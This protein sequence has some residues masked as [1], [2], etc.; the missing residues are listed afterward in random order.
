M[1]SKLLEYF[2]RAAELG[3]INKAAVDLRLSQPALSRNIALLEHEMGSALFVRGRGGVSLTEA[4]K[5]LYEQSRPLLR[6]F[7]LLKEQIGEIA[8]G[9]VAV[10]FPPSWRNVLTVQFAELLLASNPEI[11]IRI[12][13]TVS[14]SLR[15]Q[16]SSGLLD[17]CIA[18]ADDMANDDCCQMQIIREQFVAVGAPSSDLDINKGLSL[19]ALD[20]LPLIIPARPNMMRTHLEHGMALNGLELSVAIETDTLALC[21]ELCARGKGYTVAPRSALLNISGTLPV[22]WAP[23]DGAFVVWSLF[24]NARRTHSHAVRYCRNQILRITR[25]TT[26]DGRWPNAEILW[27]SVVS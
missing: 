3:S 8:H 2:L 13:E 22:S 4:G 6:Q 24:V 10:G 11:R 23:I 16:L 7:T 14:H 12:S 20:G 27:P 1:N 18:P 17:I 5:L 19:R 25:S 15:E 9:Q 21:I 26:A